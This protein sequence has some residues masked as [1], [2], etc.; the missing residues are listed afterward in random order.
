MQAPI[1]NM[2]KQSNATLNLD[3]TRDLL[4]ISHC[5]AFKHEARLVNINIISILIVL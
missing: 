5:E 4:I 3:R 2:F 1:P